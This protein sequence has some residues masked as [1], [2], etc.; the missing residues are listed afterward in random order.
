MFAGQ[1]TSSK[2]SILQA[3]NVTKEGVMCA[4]AAACPNSDLSPCPPGD[5]GETWVRLP[6]QWPDKFNDDARFHPTE[7]AAT[8]VGS[9]LLR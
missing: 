2:Y 4:Q 3:D 9:A 8:T 6:V 5:G 1:P 7:A